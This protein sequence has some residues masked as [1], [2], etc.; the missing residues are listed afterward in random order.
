MV[1]VGLPAIS[2]NALKGLAHWLNG[3]QRV[4]LKDFQNHCGG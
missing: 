2:S 3:S 4:S 1:D